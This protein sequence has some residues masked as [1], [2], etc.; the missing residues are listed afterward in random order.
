[1]GKQYQSRSLGIGAWSKKTS[2]EEHA[3]DFNS[4]ATSLSISDAESSVSESSCINLSEENRFS[5]PR[6]LI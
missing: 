6:I 2:Q 1:M 3:L 4:Q 5:Q